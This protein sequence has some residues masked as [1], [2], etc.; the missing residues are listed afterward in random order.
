MVVDATV[1][2][3]DSADWVSV[4]KEQDWSKD[5]ALGYSIVERRMRESTTYLDR[6]CPS[7]QV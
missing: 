5:R 3:N 2:M 6:V 4:E 7:R 1:G